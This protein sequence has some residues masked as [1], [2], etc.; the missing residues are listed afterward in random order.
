MCINQ[1]VL[2]DLDVLRYKY[3]IETISKLPKRVGYLVLASAVGLLGMVLSLLPSAQKATADIA[4]VTNNDYCGIGGPGY[5]SDYCTGLGF[6][7]GGS[8]GADGG[9]SCCSAS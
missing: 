1:K 3:M 2:G 8:C 9:A 4:I 5:M 7:A 6:D